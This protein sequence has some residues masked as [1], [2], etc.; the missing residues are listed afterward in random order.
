MPSTKS[1]WVKHL[2]DYHLFCAQE[3]EGIPLSISPSLPRG[4]SIAMA[5]QK[6][7]TDTLILENSRQNERGYG[8]FSWVAC[9]SVV[10]GADLAKLG[11]HINPQ[12][13]LT[14]HS[15]NL[16]TER[17][18][19]H[20]NLL[21][22]SLEPIPVS[23]LIRP[24]LTLSDFHCVSVSGPGTSQSVYGP[25]ALIYFSKCTCISF[26]V[27]Q[28]DFCGSW[29]AFEALSMQSPFTCFLLLPSLPMYC[30]EEKGELEKTSSSAGS[31]TMRGVGARMSGLRA[32]EL[33]R[34]DKSKLKFRN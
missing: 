25:Q 1:P 32:G 23:W 18:L 26:K 13:L 4:G 6:S 24:A 17:I 27:L 22:A 28:V 30:W 29:E 8:N 19:S 9:L 10:S 3:L 15:P 12:A 33:G 31:G 5:N 7:K 34:R 16:S 11:T 20:I 2:E 21:E 14:F